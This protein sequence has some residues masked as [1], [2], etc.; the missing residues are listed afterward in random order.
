M[1]LAYRFVPIESN[2]KIE[3]IYFICI[4]LWLVPWL[5][6]LLLLFRYF[7]EDNPVHCV[8]LHFILALFIS[9]SLLGG[10]LILGPYLLEWFIRKKKSLILGGDCY[11]QGEAVLAYC[12]MEYDLII[13][14]FAT[15]NLHLFLLLFT[16]F[17][18]ESVFR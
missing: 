4:K 8:C 7:M 3:F 2:M 10:V 11:P 6:T 14:V 17:V 12:Y 18:A 13:C 9:W 5:I 16:W 15:L 1:L